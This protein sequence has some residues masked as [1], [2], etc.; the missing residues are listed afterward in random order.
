M[1]KTKYKDIFIYDFD[2]VNEIIVCGD[3]HG[4]F[5]ALVNK[6]CVQY[7]I[8]D[9]IIIVA[10]DCGFG[11]E[12]LGYYDNIY[13]KNRKR[14]EEHNNYILMI[15]GNHDNPSYFTDKYIN[16]KH[17]MTIEDYSVI[18]A[19]GRSVLCVGGAV[20][21]DRQSRIEQQLKMKTS[22][23]HGDDEIKPQY[24]W[25]NELPYYDENKIEQACDYNV[26]D[27]V[28]THTA[29]SFCEKINK[30]GLDSWSLDDKTLLDDVAT[31]RCVMDKIFNK[32]IEMKQPLTYWLYGHFHQSWNSRIDDVRFIMLDIMQLQEIR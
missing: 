28:V 10:G 5:N 30:Q 25:E 26:I 21:I 23:Y 19:A 9:S 29:P 24:Y 2:D 16:Y 31:E 27:C 15:R 8:H 3:I 32:L 13:K 17:F 11:F 14:L 1:E 22:H 7:D 20:S 6:V 12:R 4:E 18:N